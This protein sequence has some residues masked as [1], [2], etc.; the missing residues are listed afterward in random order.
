MTIRSMTGYGQARRE[1]E[2]LEVVIEI[3]S[4]NHR[5]LDIIFKLPPGYSAF[6]LELA[7]LIREK[8]L[9][10]RIEVYVGRGDRAAPLYDV[11]FNKPLFDAYLG[12]LREAVSAIGAAEEQILPP[13][14]VQTLSR[15]EVI[16]LRAQERDTGADLDLVKSV[17]SEALDNLLQMREREGSVLKG[18]LLHLISLLEASVDK[19]SLRAQ[20]APA[21]FR[22]RLKQRLERTAPE[23]SVDP[24]RLAQEVAL[25]A[26]RVDVAEE[27]AR[28]KSHIG[29]LRLA[30]DEGQGGRKMDF[31]LQEVV[32]ELNTIGSKAQDSEITSQV[33]EGKANTEK[34]KEQV[35]NIE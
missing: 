26:D 3:K 4:V 22:E 27:L 13:V 15:R 16:E 10:G 9:R 20:T 7:K 24:D 8:V 18:E 29:Q 31:L 2:A 25:L 21:D 17:L 1:T 35:Q 5:F 34:L 32:R 12:V 30:I 6:E 14:L 28:L 23:I 33:I 11:S 19:I